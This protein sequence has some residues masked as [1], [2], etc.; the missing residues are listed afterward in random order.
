MFALQRQNTNHP[1]ASTENSEL[2]IGQQIVASPN[3]ANFDF[4]LSSQIQKCFIAFLSCKRIGTFPHKQ[5]SGVEGCVAFLVSDNILT[6]FQYWSLIV[7]IRQTGAARRGDIQCSSNDNWQRV[8]H[9]LLAVQHH[10]PHNNL[11]YSCQITRTRTLCVNQH[12]ITQTI[13]VLTQQIFAMH[14]TIVRWL[15]IIIVFKYDLS[16]S[17]LGGFLLLHLDPAISKC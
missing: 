10:T 7:S 16:P 1:A 9:R 14:S 12:Q 13:L 4:E 17:S 8:A 6:I 11:Y 3:F 15:S 2:R 5:C